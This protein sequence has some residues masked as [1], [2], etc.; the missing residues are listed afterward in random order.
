MAQLVNEVNNN[1]LE[2]KNNEN[3]DESLAILEPQYNMKRSSSTASGKN[4][5]DLQR[6]GSTSGGSSN[7][8]GKKSFFKNWDSVTSTDMRM[9]ILVVQA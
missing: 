5:V 7:K 2:F 6:S 3:A 9:M 8:L 1:A 4:S